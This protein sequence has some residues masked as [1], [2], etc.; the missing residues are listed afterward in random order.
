MDFI[1]DQLEEAKE[2]RRIKN[3]KN[4]HEVARS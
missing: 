3:K 4:I 2:Y 1:D